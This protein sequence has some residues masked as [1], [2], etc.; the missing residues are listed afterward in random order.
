MIAALVVAIFFGVAL[1][2]AHFVNT[3]VRMH[4]Q[5]SY[6]FYAIDQARTHYEAIGNRNQMPLFPVILSLFVDVHGTPES[7]FA[8]AKIV[9]VFLGA[10]STAL[11]WALL[12]ATLERSRAI[13]VGLVYT[14]YIAAFRAAY[15]QSECVYYALFFAAFLACVAAW[16]GTAAASAALAG[17]VC[18]LAWLTK[19]SMLLGVGIFVAALAV[20]AVAKRR[21]MD[22]IAAA[23]FVAAF[24]VVVW[25]YGA[26]SRA[27]FGGFLYNMNTTYVVWCD[28]WE[29]FLAKGAELGTNWHLLPPER[30]PS[31]TNYLRTHSLASIA[32]REVRGLARIF[33]NAA[34]GTGFQLF[35]I[36]W[37]VA[38]FR[39]IPRPGARAYLTVPWVAL[40]VLALGFYGDIAAGNRFV[41]ALFLPAAWWF[42]RATKIDAKKTIVFALAGAIALPLVARFVYAGG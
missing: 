3:D 24:V 36:A 37:I 30:V 14:L 15:V 31:M 40:H 32:L 22:A 2:Q 25:P 7:E 20:R 10:F 42:F 35:S 38:F 6:L 9:G 23:V 41:L 11:V 8:K 26:N 34:L 29:Q 13:A 1:T 19:A 21:P 5:S 17:A 16:K 12:A 27:H 18:A 4:D 28:S 33:G 39:Q